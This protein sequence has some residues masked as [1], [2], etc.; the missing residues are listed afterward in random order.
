MKTWLKKFQ[1]LSGEEIYKILKLRN[2]IFIVEQKC[3]YQDVDDKD[4]AAYHLFFEDNGEIIGCLRILNR[5]IS[6]DEVSIGR[7]AVNKNYRGKHIA[8]DMLVKAIDF[9]EKELKET[10]IKIQAQTYLVNF[11]ASLGFKKVSNEYLEDNIPHIDMLYKNLNTS[12]KIFIENKKLWKNGTM[13]QYFQWYLKPDCGLWNNAAKEAKQLSETGITAVWLPPAY[14]GAAGKNDVGYGVYD[15]YDLGEF[16][17]KGSIATKYG[18]KEEYINAIKTLHKNNIQVYADISIDHMIGADELEEV[19]AVEENPANRKQETSG[20]ETILAWTKF[21]FPGRNNKYSEFKW[22][23]KHFHG[24]DY[25]ERTKR[26]SIFRFAD[27]CWDDGVDC[28]NGNYDY[29]MGADIDLNDDEVIQELKDWSKW[30][31]DLTNVD[32]FR[33]DAVKHMNYKFL[34]YLL[35]VLR[36]ESGEE[37]FAV[38]EYWNGDINTLINYINE[39]KGDM[40]LFDVPLHFNFFKAS[41]SNGNYDMRNILKGTLIE[42]NPS[43]AVTFVEN[44]DT[45]AGQAL[46]SSV[47]GWF[48]PLAYAIILLRV[49]GYPCVFYGDYYGVENSIAPMKEKL[50]ILL[51][52]RQFKAY[53]KQNDYFDDCNIV[54]WTRE[55]DSEHANSGLAVLLSDGSG[56]NKRMYI[57]KQFSGNTFFDCT[58]SIKDKTL[59]DSEGF[60]TFIVDGGNI[61][62]WVKEQ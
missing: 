14:K 26:N 8:K 2:E 44:H 28:E 60:G 1:D 47:E 15:L 45:Q 49:D 31:L 42:K 23:H 11:Y 3:A 12:N 30:Y 7:L 18:T 20:K 9:I 32:G 19:E 25:D 61:A 21:N 51:N 52:A 29:L 62:V 54:G 10:E 37:L 38:G 58:G 46:E 53:G 24:V 50:N 5:G 39:T 35:S 13:M 4:E 22:N 6:F 57:G 43:K 16:N 59:I 40:S 55:G 36:K 41:K 56:G 33:L 17:Q 48:K 27:K 34:M